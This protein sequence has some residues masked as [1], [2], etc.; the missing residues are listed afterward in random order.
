[1]E[2]EGKF[3]KNLM[4]SKMLPLWK[5]LSLRSNVALVLIILLV[6]M[7]FA[8][9]SLIGMNP[10]PKP[11][12]AAMDPKIS[13][14]GSSLPAGSK[15][16]AAV[17]FPSVAALT[18]GMS[19]DQ[20]EA[21]FRGRKI[22]MDEGLLENYVI[23]F[24][25]RTFESCV[26]DAIDKPIGDIELRDLMELRVLFLGNDM[27]NFEDLVHIFDFT[28]I[29]RGTIGQP[30]Y[31]EGVVFL[32]KL[33]PGRIIG[34]EFEPGYDNG[35]R[36]IH[37]MA[38][39]STGEFFPGRFIK[40]TNGDGTT[41]TFVPGIDREDVFTP[42]VVVDGRHYPG[43]LLGD[44][45]IPGL[46]HDGVFHPVPGYEGIIEGYHDD[47]NMAGLCTPMMLDPAADL[48]FGTTGERCSGIPHGNLLD[49]SDPLGIGDADM[50][51][52]ASEICHGGDRS[53]RNRD[54]GNLNVSCN[55]MESLEGHL[56][57]M[58][59]ASDRYQ[60]PRQNWLTRVQAQ[61]TAYI[62]AMKQHKGEIDPEKPCLVYESDLSSG[63]GGMGDPEC[64][65]PWGD[66]GFGSLPD[67]EIDFSAK[68]KIYLPDPGPEFDEAADAAREIERIYTII[69]VCGGV[70]IGLG[71]MAAFPT[72]AGFGIGMAA[73]FG[74]VVVVTS[75]GHS[76]ADRRE[77]EILRE[78]AQRRGEA[79]AAEN[80]EYG[81]NV[82]EEP[83]SSDDEWAEWV[84]SSE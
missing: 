27:H 1:M 48:S 36:F 8:Q 34:N 55:Q 3:M 26:R 19:D 68:G 33:I 67:L 70:I 21:I 14:T 64:G 75:M 46:F 11:T 73:Y 15:L 57:L 69:G 66:I 84:G 17:T 74:T 78:Q 49:P 52:G 31:L 29:I 30:G 5:R 4:L 45:F 32:G 20:W 83:E 79:A 37:G 71:I 28:F 53:A 62:K 56:L 59:E 58:Q 77:R 38:I 54:D 42:G 40:S 50:G 80:P 22:A 10:E 60:Y 81:D 61:N 16:S 44:Q 23:N 47:S 13:T 35:H 51:S 39:M 12:A 72:P 65:N 24:Q 25:S 82:T 2:K 43:I 18:T 9:A 7:P 41:V 6:F 76:A 63:P